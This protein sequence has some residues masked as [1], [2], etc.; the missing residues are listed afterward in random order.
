[1]T[2]NIRPTEIERK[3]IWATLRKA[4]KVGLYWGIVGGVL[5]TFVFKVIAPAYPRVAAA[6]FAAEMIFVL[7]VYWKARRMLRRK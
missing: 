7:V 3:K 4:I 5:N 6:I 2:E 1:M